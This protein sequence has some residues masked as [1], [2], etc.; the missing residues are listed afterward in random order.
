[1]KFDAIDRTKN[2]NISYCLWRWARNK[3][4]FLSI[5][6]VAF[7]GDYRSGSAG[8]PDA[9]FIEGMLHTVDGVWRPSAMIL[10]LRDLC[11]EWGDEMSLVLQPPTD[12]YAIVV[13][14]KCEPAIS[15]L[16]YGI[17]S[18]R[19][20]LEKAHFFDALNPAIDYVT[21]ALV[22]D[23]NST[24]TKADFITADELRQSS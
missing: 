8:A 6:R 4:P 19:S 3:T 17:D 13:S 11:Y 7:A 2:G 15:T 16:C 5:V 23:W 12:I 9:H 20:V 21:Q 22:A 1:M 18:K 10:D 24:L 14:A